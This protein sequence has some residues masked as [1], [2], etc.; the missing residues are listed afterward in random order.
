MSLHLWT[1][2]S[3]AS[4]AY[5]K[6][7]IIQIRDKGTSWSL[8]QELKKVIGNGNGGGDEQPQA[9]ISFPL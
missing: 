1:Y 6:E 5:H 8:M 9:K 2:D 3:P 7:Y 4:I